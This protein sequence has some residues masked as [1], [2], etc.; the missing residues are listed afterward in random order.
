MRWI[1]PPGNALIRVEMDD[2][3]VTLRD[4]CLETFNVVVNEHHW[5]TNTLLFTFRI[6][7]LSLKDYYILCTWKV[8]GLFIDSQ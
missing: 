6:C 2:L 8:N 4:G 1:T 7:K 5:N 3:L